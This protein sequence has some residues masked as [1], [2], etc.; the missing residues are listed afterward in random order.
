MPLEDTNGDSKYRQDV[1]IAA[2]ETTARFYYYEQKASWNEIILSSH[3]ILIDAGLPGNGDPT[4]PFGEAEFGVRVNPDSVSRIEFATP[5]RVLDAGTTTQDIIVHTQDEYYNDKPVSKTETLELNSDSAWCAFVTNKGTFNYVGTEWSWQGGP[6]APDAQPVMEIS[7]GTYEAVFSYSD[8]QRG[9]PRIDVTGTGAPGDTW[10]W[11]QQSQTVNPAE[12]DHLSFESDAYT[13]ANPLEAGATSWALKVQ[14]QDKFNNKSEVE[15][16]E[17]INLLLTGADGSV[18]IFSTT[19]S[20]WVEAGKIYIATSTAEA[21]FYARIFKAGTWELKA[22]RE[23]GGWSPATQDIEVRGGQITQLVINS[24]P[25]NIIVDYSG[26]EVYGSTNYL[27]EVQTQDQYGNMSAVGS[28]V[29]LSLWSDSIESDFSNDSVNWGINIV[30]ISSGSYATQFYY[31]DKISADINLY[32]DENPS[33]GWTQATQPI[34]VYPS[35]AASFNVIHDGEASVY[36][37]EEIIV[38][39]VDIYGNFADGHPD[40]Y[41]P[42]GSSSTWK[43]YVS[44]ASVTPS[45]IGHPAGKEPTINYPVWN[46]QDSLDDGNPGRADLQLTDTVVTDEPDV[47][48]IDITVTDISSGA[49][50]GVS[51]EIIVTGALVKPYSDPETGDRVAPA[52]IYQDRQNVLMERLDIKTNYSTAT[53][54]SMRVDLGGEVSDEEIPVVRIWKDGDGDAVFTHPDPAFPNNGIDN[55]SSPDILL[56]SGVFVGGYSELDLTQQLG[57]PQ[58]VSETPGYYFIT[59]DCWEYAEPEQKM[60]LYWDKTYFSQTGRWSPVGAQVADNNFAIETPTVTV[61]TSPGDIIMYS[62]SIVEQTDTVKQGAEKV[63]FLKMEMTT[64]KYTIDWTEVNITLTGSNIID[65]DIKNIRIYKDANANKTLE[66]EADTLITSGADQFGTEIE[67][68]AIIK[69]VNP[70]DLDQQ[71]AQTITTSTQTYFVALT[72]DDSA[73]IG[74]T[75]G[76]KIDSPDR[77]VAR[78]ENGENRVTLYHDKNKDGKQDP[79]EPDL[80]PAATENI[81]IQP[82]IDT[83]QIAKDSSLGNITQGAENRVMSIL[84]LSADA[85]SIIWKGV[86]IDKTGT[87]SDKWVNAVKVWWYVSGSTDASGKPVVNTAT[88]TPTGL[89]D[90]L[91][92]E[93]ADVFSSSTTEMLFPEDK[94]QDLRTASKKYLITYDIDP[95]AT[96]AEDIGLQA[97]TSGYFNVGWPDIVS[98]AKIP[99]E[100]SPKTVVPYSDSILVEPSDATHLISD[101]QINQSDK[102]LPLIELEMTSD[103]SY[104]A[105]KDNVSE[106]KPAL[107]LF[108]QGSALDSEITNIQLWYDSNNDGVL[109]TDA[110]VVISTSNTFFDGVCKINITEENSQDILPVTKGYFLTVDI[111]DLALPGHT[112]KLGINEAANF[113]VSSPDT[114]EETNLPFSTEEHNINASPRIVTVTPSDA[115]P[116]EEYQGKKDMLMETLKM[117][118]DGFEVDWTGLLVFRTGNDAAS[119][120]D[121]SAVKIYKDIQS[122]GTA[123]F[124]TLQP[125]KDILVSSGVF[126]DSSK[127]MAFDLQDGTQTVTTEPKYWFITYDIA[128]DAMPG[129]KVGLRIANNSYFKVVY[130]HSVSE[131]NI[132]FETSRTEIMATVDTLLITPEDA[133]VGAVIQGDDDVM[134]TSL[135]LETNQ[136]AV[137]VTGIDVHRI[138]TGTDNDVATV[139]LYKD[140]DNNGYLEPASGGG[141]DELVSYG[142][143]VFIDGVAELRFDATK[144]QSIGTAGQR[145]FLVYDIAN[146]AEVGK[147]VGTRFLDETD[148][149]FLAADDIV[150][151]NNLPFQSSEAEVEEYADRIT[152]IPVRDEDGK[153]PT[154][155]TVIQGEDD[156]VVDILK[157]TTRTPQIG[158]PEAD[159]LWSGVRLSVVGDNDDTDIEAVKI[160]RDANNNGVLETSKDELVSSGADTLSAGSVN[161]DFITPQNIGTAFRTFFIVCDIAIEAGPI[162]TVGTK[163]DSSSFFFVSSPNTVATFVNSNGNVDGDGNPLQDPDEPATFPLESSLAT[164]EA[165]KI[166]FKTEDIAPAG[167]R[168]G[169]KGVPMAK[170]EIKVS[171]LTSAGADSEPTFNYV[172]V[173]KTGDLAD[174]DIDAVNIY[175]DTDG[176]GQLDTVAD[177]LISA[178]DDT[179]SSGVVIVNIST[180]NIITTSG[181]T[182]FLTY[183][184]AAAAKVNSL[185]GGRIQENTNFWIDITPKQRIIEEDASPFFETSYLFIRHLYTPT[186]PVVKV[187]EWI[188]SATTVKGSWKS[189]TNS[190]M[191]ITHNMYMAAG[192]PWRDLGAVKTSSA[193]DQYEYEANI[194]TTIQGLSL[195][196]GEVYMFYAKTASQDKD[197]NEVLWSLPGEAS[198]TV[199]LNPPTSP[200]TPTPD[201]QRQNKVLLSYNVTWVDSADEVSATESGVMRYDIQERKDTSPVWKTVTYVPGNENSHWFENRPAGHFYYYRVRAQDN[202]GNWG[203]WSEVS[204]AAV[205]G[206]P[207]EAVSEVSNY[208]NPARFDLGDAKTRITYIL[209]QDAE[210][211]VYLYDMMGH[212]VK[213]WKFKKGMV[214]GKQGENHFDWLGINEIGTGVAKGGYILRIIVKSSEG[215]VEKTRKIGIVR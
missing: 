60:K 119:D 14:T 46:F 127:L 27:I 206:L 41:N 95:F 153:P 172:R 189:M 132:P 203:E 70:N 166:S 1:T 185:V 43:Y 11:G 130:P 161:I 58:T 171:S 101:N 64:T 63:G 86:R 81:E 20:P 42:Y 131:D 5:S 149:K 186:T 138:G 155:E 106:S 34:S 111:S 168:Q 129:A 196:H 137:I 184:L 32:V 6:W 212:L 145:Y 28:K 170:F 10:G 36:V 4:A 26:Y 112:V 22:S 3:T 147:T 100:V 97:A 200:G 49:L 21:Y 134:I 62:D 116:V 208:P 47:P 37:P 61:K 59:V 179:F 162:H 35:D 12:I 29:N 125:Y 215:T 56:S 108:N 160:Y 211:E 38:T 122:S 201:Q 89:S 24:E 114:V 105:W 113:V 143:D 156:V 23:T 92:S 17:A 163:F 44:K 151:P 198:F 15:Q 73:Q 207:E 53:W 197:T 214:G 124:S 80:F 18:Y 109:T 152:V 115:A 9:N 204:D 48:K 181:R 118:C 67:G 88:D 174:S 205:T 50:S 140:S 121:I 209:N 169:V 68:V 45:S 141:N 192:S 98:D 69:L 148:F 120:S 7:T 103:I 77:L 71:R 93:G 104:A 25:R 146:L 74:A 191:G 175:S 76:L 84:D 133:G 82:T 202:A 173:I 94:F 52:N 142:T 31:K 213:E 210:V 85:H 128:T 180:E 159:A 176:D 187:Q 193:D 117:Q 57:Y 79:D 51:D 150:A 96:E 183:D 194:E 87:L 165:M 110:D 107:T 164:V 39:A 30:S 167:E 154:P 65:G 19:I 177:E 182:F 90:K 190:S 123:G 135:N 75:V 178:G 144:Y 157:M 40:E 54:Y 139:K 83:L 33:M 99:V 188:N 13:S 126:Q 136:N 102:D 199:D 78:D 195:R 72:I 2:G 66:S 55:D 158:D 91:I 8:N 16:T